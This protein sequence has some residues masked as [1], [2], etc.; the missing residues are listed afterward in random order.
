[1]PRFKL[2]IEYDGTPFTGWARSR[3]SILRGT[4]VPTECATRSMRG[5]VRI[6]SRCCRPRKSSPAS[7]RDFRRNGGIIS[8]ASSIAGRISRSSATAPGASRGGS[9]PR[10]CTRPPRRWSDAT[11]SPP[12]GPPN[13]RPN[14]RSRRSIGSRPSARARKSAFSPRRARSYT[15]RCARWWARW[16]WWARANGA[17]KILPPRSPRAR[18]TPAGRSPRPRVCICRAWSI[19]GTRTGAACPGRSA[20]R[21]DALL[22]RDPLGPRR[23]P[24]DPGSSARHYMPRLVRGTPAN[25]PEIFFQDAPVDR[26]ERL[27]VR[28]RHALVDL[29]RGSA[30]QPELHHWTIVL[31]E[32]GVGGAARGGTRRFMPG[33]L[34]DRARDQ[35]DERS[36]LGQKH[37]GVR[38]LELQPPAH[39][40]SRCLAASRL[41]EMLERFLRMA[42]V[43]A[44][45]ESRARLP[46]DQVHGSI[47]DVDRGELQVRRSEMLG[48]FIERLRHQRAH[49][50]DEP[51]DR[52]V[53]KLRG[54]DMPLPAGH[55]QRA[56]ERAAPA[57]LEGVAQSGGARRLADE[58]MIEH[59]AALGR[60]AQQLDRAVDRHAFLI[61]GDEQR[62]RAAR[63]AGCGADVIDRS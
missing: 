61:A 28:G 33:D 56:V 1:M 14:R 54:G 49:Q 7:M 34:G 43:E 29:M 38:G 2:L 31:D 26:G 39:L 20:A 13:A 6:R 11:T 16:C 36:G 3:I 59:D 4:G 42:I 32:A 21:S 45:V 46:G 53:R 22:N 30:D 44:D 18:A 9:M 57:D 52:I 62:N 12:S 10:R 41:D 40:F 60:P 35:I 24:V 58:G 8:I 37:V 15:I 5:C 27:E 48:A 25:S 51:A 19:R 47:A 17:R 55:G 63:P 23:K 50:R